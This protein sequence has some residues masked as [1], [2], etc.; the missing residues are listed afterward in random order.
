[1]FH[2]M[3]FIID[4]LDMGSILQA[5][6]AKRL[7]HIHDSQLDCLAAFSTHGIEEHLHILF[8]A[9]MTAQPD[10]SS[11]VK[12]SNHDGVGVSFMN[13]YCIN[14]NGPKLQKRWWMIS[15]QPPHEALFHSAYLIPTQ[16]VK[17]RH[18]LDG[19]LSTE[20]AHAILKSLSESR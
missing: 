15:K 16:V 1:M 10:G 2:D 13:G 12:I 18:S 19:H 8:S 11:L 9:A 5:Y 3:K 7:L 4:N 6:F 14:A 20:F 17:F